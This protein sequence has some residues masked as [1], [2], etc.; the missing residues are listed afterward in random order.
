MRDSVPVSLDIEID[1]R[2]KQPP[3]FPGWIDWSGKIV[4]IR[5]KRCRIERGGGDYRATGHPSAALELKGTPTELQANLVGRDWRDRQQRTLAMF[6]ECVRYPYLI[7]TFKPSELWRPT[8]FYDLPGPTAT[9][10]FRLQA[11]GLRLLWVPR[12]NSVG[13]ALTVGRVIA[14]T[15]LTHAVE[16]INDTNAPGH[17]AANINPAS[18]H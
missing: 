7:L 9:A 6:I 13:S 3:P 17:T 8:R 16:A 12:G 1:D 10:L 11:R 15:L 18:P 4:T 5:T 2:E 14:Y